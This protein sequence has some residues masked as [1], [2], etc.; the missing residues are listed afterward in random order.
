[1]YETVA[2][3]TQFCK[4]KRVRVV[5]KP[6]QR[7]EPSDHPGGYLKITCPRYYY[8]FVGRRTDK[9]WQHT[10]NKAFE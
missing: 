8:F 7:K 2:I 4:K 10:L 3:N 1:M 6:E 5:V 9:T